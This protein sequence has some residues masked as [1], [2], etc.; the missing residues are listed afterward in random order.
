[1][2]A[3]GAMGSMA[4][5]GWP[6]GEHSLPAWSHPHQGPPPI[7]TT[8]HLAVGNMLTDCKTVSSSSLP[9]L[10]SVLLPAFAAPARPETAASCRR[11]STVAARQTSKRPPDG[12]SNKRRTCTRVRRSSRPS[13]GTSRSRLRTCYPALRPVRLP[14]VSSPRTTSRRASPR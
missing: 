14:C 8:A 10:P 6:L 12:A 9:S 5:R 11:D 4:S 7:A 2:G 1:M 13:P 3:T